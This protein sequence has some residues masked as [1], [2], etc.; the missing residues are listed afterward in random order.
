M[1]SFGSID[2]RASDGHW[3]AL[4]LADMPQLDATE[5]ACNWA[6]S[7]HAE[8]RLALAYALAEP[9]PLVGDDVVI[10]HLAHDRVG[11]VRRA[12]RWARRVRMQGEVAKPLTR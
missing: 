3:L 8:K 1:G 6:L 4:S 5:I 7:H 12:A 2:A 9:F 10:D 11:A